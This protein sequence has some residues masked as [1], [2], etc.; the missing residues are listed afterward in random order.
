MPAKNKTTRRTHIIKIYCSKCNA[1]LYKYRKEKLGHL[2]KCYKSS[3][4]EDRTR[5]DMKCPK[6]GQLFA[7]EA[8]YHNRP[9]NKIIQGKVYLKR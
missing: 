9:A 8:V 5:G 7:R 1:F 2:V 3:I 6:C 4:I